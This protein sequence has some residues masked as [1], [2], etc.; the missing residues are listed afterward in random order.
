MA[1]PVCGQQGSEH[2]VLPAELHR[3][4]GSA[5]ASRA[6]VFRTGPEAGDLPR[7]QRLGELMPGQGTEG[8]Q[9]LMRADPQD[10]AAP[11]QPVEQQ[12][13]AFFGPA[14]LEQAM[15]LST[16]RGQPHPGSIRPPGQSRPHRHRRIGRALQPQDP[17]DA[18][19][20]GTVQPPQD[21]QP[22]SRTQ[23]TIAAAD[24]LVRD[25]QRPSQLA[26]RRARRDQQRMHQLP[27]NA[28]QL[29]SFH[30]PTV[31]PRRNPASNVI[32][33]A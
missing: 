4:G 20:Q 18:A 19:D 28:I 27:V 25:P 32:S 17:V 5:R 23:G 3:S 2:L 15:N 11:G 14:R 7:S 8:V 26:E 13:V 10:P 22:E 16:A 29:T 21:L 30:A 31:H 33:T 12:R 6:R 1:R 24:G 9:Q